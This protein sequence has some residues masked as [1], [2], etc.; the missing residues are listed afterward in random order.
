MIQEDQV[1]AVAEG[2]VVS[3]REASRHVQVDHPPSRIIGDIN[4]RTTRSRSRNVSHFAHS[5]FVATFEPKDIGHS[6]SESN[7]VNAMHEEFQNFERNEVWELL[8]PPPNCKPIGIK[9]VWK[10]KWEKIARW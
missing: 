3:R 5:D 8:E 9:W 7:W 10:T 1:E 6:L 2:E 4:E